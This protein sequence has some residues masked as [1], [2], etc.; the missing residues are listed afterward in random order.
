MSCSHDISIYAQV[1]YSGLVCGPRRMA[2]P[3][4]GHPSRLALRRSHLRMTVAYAAYKSRS[5]LKQQKI[6]T[7]QNFPRHVFQRWRITFPLPE[8]R[9]GPERRQAPPNSLARKARRRSRV[10]PDGGSGRGPRFRAFR[11]AFLGAGGPCFRG[12]EPSGDGPGRISEPSSRRIKANARTVFL[13]PVQSP[14]S[15]EWQ[16]ACVTLGRVPRTSRCPAWQSQ[17]ASAAPA[18]LQAASRSAPSWAG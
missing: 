3:C 12:R 7:C 14:F 17:T 8:K 2:A 16:G 9:R 10:P 11:S 5:F 1:R 4:E 6:P 15:Q 18:P 13:R